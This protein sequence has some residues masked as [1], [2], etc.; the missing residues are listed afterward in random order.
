M[1]PNNITSIY[2]KISLLKNII[3]D[4]HPFYIDYSKQIKSN[5]ED[6]KE[7][8][9]NQNKHTWS[10][11]YWYKNGESHFKHIDE[12]G[13]LAAF[14][15]L[16]KLNIDYNEGGLVFWKDDEEIY[17]DE[18]LDYGD[19][20][21]LDQASYYHEVKKIKVTDKQIGRL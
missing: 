13:E 6:V 2:Q 12:Y 7:V 11:F 20:V 9:K 4:G 1:A 19:L 17:L 8:L 15:I 18:K 14:L 21:F 16:S 10:C 5:P 3:Y